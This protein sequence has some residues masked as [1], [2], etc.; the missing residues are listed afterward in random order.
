MLSQHLAELYGVSVSALNQAVKRN[1]ERFPEDFMF[2]LTG[3]EFENLKSQIVTSS[4]GGLRRAHP[5]AFTEQGVAMLSSV[6]RSP[7]AAEVNIAIMR[8]FVQLRRL[9][10]S[11]R[12]LARKIEALERKYDEQFAVVFN[13]IKQLIAADRDAKAKPKRRIGFHAMSVLPGEIEARMQRLIAAVFS[14]VVIGTSLNA[15]AATVVAVN[16]D[17]S[18][19]DGGSS[20]AYEYGPDSE[21]A[22]L[23][24]GWTPSLSFGDVSISAQITSNNPVGATGE[25][26]LTTQT[27]SDWHKDPAT[28]KHRQP[29]SCAT[30]QV[31]PPRLAKPARTV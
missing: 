12:D 20:L 30:V 24:V 15:R 6:L 18:S 9:M 7:R 21:T 17:T 25:A 3:E 14:L 31:P 13:A 29:V 4:W 23:A 16:G 10:D 1:L 5:Y 19:S 26:F 8:T 2:Q 22:I 27:T 11:N 28:P